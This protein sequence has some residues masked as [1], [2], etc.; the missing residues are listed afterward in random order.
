MLQLCDTGP[1]DLYTGVGGNGFAA[2]PIERRAST[3]RLRRRKMAPINT[4]E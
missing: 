3:Q 2:A 4:L 1:K